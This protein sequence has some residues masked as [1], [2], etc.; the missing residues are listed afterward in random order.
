MSKQADDLVNENFVRALLVLSYCG[1]R[2]HVFSEY[3]VKFY[4][5]KTPEKLHSVHG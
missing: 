5:V 2:E 1:F 4:K 3:E